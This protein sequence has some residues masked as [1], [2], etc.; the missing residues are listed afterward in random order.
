[1]RVSEILGFIFHI[2]HFAA[3]RARAL[4]RRSTSS[5]LS[6]EIFRDRSRCDCAGLG[7]RRIYTLESKP[8]QTDIWLSQKYS[9]IPAMEGKT[10]LID[11]AISTIHPAPR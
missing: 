1:M 6:L 3:V 11:K 8:K 2:S 5:P 7:Q 4:P 10:L 9:T